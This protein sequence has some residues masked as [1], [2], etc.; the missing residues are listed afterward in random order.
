MSMPHGETTGRSKPCS[1]CGAGGPRNAAGFVPRFAHKLVYVL[2]DPT[3]NISKIPGE[4]TAIGDHLVIGYPLLATPDGYTL[5][6]VRTFALPMQ[7]GERT[8]GLT[9]ESRQQRHVALLHDVV[10]DGFEN[11][12]VVWVK[13]DNMMHAVPANSR[14]LPCDLYHMGKWFTSYSLLGADEAK[15]LDAPQVAELDFSNV[16][17]LIQSRGWMKPV[18]PDSVMQWLKGYEVI[19]PMPE[20]P[21]LQ[22]LSAEAAPLGLMEK[23]KPDFKALANLPIMDLS[24]KLPPKWK[25]RVGD[26]VRW[27]VANHTMLA[28]VKAIDI[29]D[30]HNVL[31]QLCGGAEVFRDFQNSFLCPLHM[32]GWVVSN[33]GQLWINMSKPSEYGR[34]SPDRF[35]MPLP[36]QAMAFNRADPPPMESDPPEQ[37]FVQCANLTP[38][39]HKQAALAEEGTGSAVAQI[40]LDHEEESE[41]WDAFAK[42]CANE[43][44]ITLDDKEGERVLAFFVKMRRRLCEMLD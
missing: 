34:L 21:V 23:L 25:P 40:R 15:R 30:P 44:G 6:W 22:A 2:G 43:E 3:V 9:F 42:Y 12:A 10:A 37:A 1:T 5:L 18:L 4:Y 17:D 29:A 32:V 20:P 24:P 27:K 41:V 39:T 28:H 11:I 26:G 8:D 16:R 13:T 33:N 35:M 7:I 19:P 31:I 36:A 38:A 14:Q